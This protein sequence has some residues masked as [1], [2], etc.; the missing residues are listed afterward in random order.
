[1]NKTKLQYLTS[2]LS[3]FLLGS[4][5]TDNLDESEIL[6]ENALIGEWRLSSLVVSEKE[7]VFQNGI[8][9]TTIISADSFLHDYTLIFTEDMFSTLGGYSYRIDNE[10]NGENLSSQE[11]SIA[12]IS[13]QGTYTIDLDDVSF[14]ADLYEFNFDGDEAIE[15]D[16]T[17]SAKFAFSENSDRL[18]LTQERVVS[19]F[20]N[21]NSVNVTDKSVSVW[22][23]VERDL[24]CEDAIASTNTAQIAYDN[25]ATSTLQALCNALKT[26]LANQIVICGDTNN[27]LQARIDA[28]GD[29]M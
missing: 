24:A 11:F 18:T 29:C 23:R 9:S 21:A 20:I 6:D 2:M 7:E 17:I 8:P 26:A 25:A 1:M 27:E 12:N 14:G 22:L 3:L 10:S 5:L 15:F 4:C 13:N 16:Q 28:L 19:T